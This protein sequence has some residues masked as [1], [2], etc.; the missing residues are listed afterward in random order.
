MRFGHWGVHRLR[1]QRLISPALL[2]VVLGSVAM[3]LADEIRGL[4]DLLM[5]TVAVT[6]MLIG[7]G[8]AAL[9][10]RGWMASI[11][12]SILGFV[13]V[14]LRVGRLGG[15]LV[16]LLQTLAGL[17][18][19]V[20]RWLLSSSDLYDLLGSPW[21]DWMPVVLALTE[22]WAGVGT[23]LARVRDWVLALAA[24]ESAFDPAAVALVWS[25]ILWAV[26]AWAGWMVRRRDW[27]LRGVAPAGA[28]LVATF[29][30]VGGELSFLLVL[31]GAVLLLLAASAYDVCV[32]RWQATGID[33]AELGSDIALAVIPLSLVLVIVAA[34]AP[35]LSVQD[36]IEFVHRLGDEQTDGSRTFAGS[37]GME[38]RP[39]REQWTVFDEMRNVGL[40][41]RH[42]LG[43]GP[44]LSEQVVMVISTGDLPPGIMK[45]IMA[46]S[47]PRYYW[48][49]VTYDRYVRY[50]W[51][52]GETETVEYEA[53]K[54]VITSTLTT[55]RTVRQKV[56]VV[57]DL[58][59]LLHVA[60]K[61]A[62]VDQDYSVAWR[63]HGDAFGAIVEAATYRADSLVPIVSEEQLRSAGSDYPEW[64][65]SRYLALPDTIPERVLS[66]ARDLTATEPTPYDRAR[67]IEDH[68]RAISYTLDVPTPPRDRDVVDYFLFDLQKGYCDYYATAM[69]VLAR[70]AGLP[71]R[72]V[73]GYA[74][75]SYDPVEARYIVTEADAHAWVEVYFPGYEWVEFEPTGGFP[76]IR[77]SAEE[78]ALY[79]WPEP[80]G[81]LEPAIA[82]WDVS[83]WP[84]LGV[85]SGLALLALVGVVWRAADGWWLRHL[86]PVA[87][88][89]TLYRRL[90][91]H[92]RWLAV[93][94]QAGDTP[95]E[96]ATSFA[97]RLAG[98][99]QERRWGEVLTPAAQEVRRLTGFYVQASYSPHL[100]GV[101]D[102][103]R[104]IRTW[105][106]VCWR[107]WLARVWRNK[108]LS[109][110]RQREQDAG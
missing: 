51:L 4:D 104:A 82:W 75:G 35:S 94:M 20:F 60:G 88:M 100:P 17:A 21:P 67:A 105:E 44:E 77:R 28:L 95:Y 108:L 1:L 63:S 39:G 23:L 80:E 48:R 90:Q 7:W 92:G 103:A 2:L 65:Q 46:E 83:A 31:L 52:T 66:L 3:G 81:A 27:P 53:A 6:G 110:R 42:L 69:V 9:P 18:W 33:F 56:Q 43:S 57:G 87:A 93:P 34:L 41:R 29:S 8:L 37:L 11:L 91:R 106:R 16:V 107:L 19:N 54:A 10:L 79:E 13:G 38:P 109:K 58:G 49:G 45:A 96:F 99:V 36:V 70:A 86:K 50:G 22:L 72:Y 25:L 32:R 71:A 97:G 84:W 98:L 30:Y 101:T 14:F 78:T 68:L 47:P 59:G 76:P 85:T 89:T 24:G 102:Q 73:A 12:A 26:S 55:Q 64:V 61:L 5:L 62:A 40:P 74:T 15:E